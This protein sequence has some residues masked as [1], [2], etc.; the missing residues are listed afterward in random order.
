MFKL[1]NLL[2]NDF[3][4]NELPPCFS[5]ESFRD[6]ISVNEIINICNYKEK[7]NQKQTTPLFFSGYKNES[8][9]RKFAIPNY[10]SYMKLAKNIVDNSEHIFPLLSKSKGAS[11]TSPTSKRPEKNEAFSKKCRNF[12]ESKIEIEKQYYANN[13]EL[14]LDITS[15]F[16]SIYTHSIAWAVD[17]KKKAKNKQKDMELVGN[18]LDKLVQLMNNNQTNGILVGNALSRII[19]EIIL[20][21]VDEK[22]Q[23]EFKKIKYKRYVDDYYIYTEN[24]YDIPIIISVVRKYLNEYELS[25]N[26]NK[27]Q[28][29][30]SPFIYDKPWLES[31]RQYINLDPFTF[32]NSLIID[33][34]RF[35]DVSLLKYGLKIISLYNYSK[36]QWESFE[37]KIFNLLATFPSLADIVLKILL[38]NISHI[39]KLHLKKTIYSIIDKSIMLTYDQEL[40]WMVWY[41]KVFKI[42][43]SIKCYMKLFNNNNSLAHIILL[44]YLKTNHSGIFNHNDVKRWRQD[45][46]AKMKNNNNVMSSQYWLLAYEGT[47][48]KWFNFDNTQFKAVNSSQEFKA[49]LDNEIFFYSHDH[50]FKWW[51]AISP[52]RAILLARLKG[53]HCKPFT[54][55]TS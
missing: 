24:G 1:D 35:K 43:I 45:K 55:Y 19:S 41:I 8:A 50:H 18:Q 21:D 27:I 36:K 42:E 40:I 15:F 38:V 6:K 13:Y 31:I 32:F 29:N 12:Q 17:T 28:I 52:I 53:G 37:P 51:F 34:K 20:C 2:C 22:V 23:N 30:E 9:R 25:I 11:L 39:S 44:D 5:T 3:F 54:Y 16:D 7:E 14:R 46:A 48:N 4:P 33:Y 47:R 10:V 26:E 49:L